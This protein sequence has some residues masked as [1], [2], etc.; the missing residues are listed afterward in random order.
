MEYT[1]KSLINLIVLGIWVFSGINCTASF[2]HYSQGLA[3]YN[4][5]RY[6][7]AIVEYDKAIELSPGYAEAY[8]NRAAAKIAL[9]QYASAISDCNK[10][11]E[12]DPKYVLAYNN[13]GFAKASLGNYASAIADYNRALHL[14]P[15]YVLFITIGQRRRLLYIGTLL[16]FQ[17]VIKYCS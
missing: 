11:I 1:K 13:R 15:D 4:A 10:V 16:P 7:E 2:Y 12:L 17:T 3:K 8:N 14:E 6:R 9:H 5:Q